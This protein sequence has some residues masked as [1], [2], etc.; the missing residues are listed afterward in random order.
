MRMQYA[1]EE[2]EDNRD[3]DAR[4]ERSGEDVCIS[5]NP[6]II[7][8]RESDEH[9]QHRPS[10]HGMATADAKIASTYRDVRRRPDGK[11]ERRWRRKCGGEDEGRARDM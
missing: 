8:A 6:G 3:R 5:P 1:P 9:R 7:S 11:G 10:E 2:D 4:V